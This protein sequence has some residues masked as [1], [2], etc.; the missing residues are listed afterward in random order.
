MPC[1]CLFCLVLALALGC[2]CRL[3][4]TPLMS[5][6]VQHPFP[7]SRHCP[8]LL[9][10]LSGIRNAMR[11]YRRSLTP[12]S[13]TKHGSF[14]HVHAAPTSSLASGC[15]S[16]NCAPIVLS[17]ATKH[18]GWF[19]VFVSEPALNLYTPLPRL[20]DRARSIPS[21]TSWC[22]GHGQCTRW[23]SPTPFSMSILTS[24]C[25]ASSPLV[26]S[27]PHT[28]IM[29]AFFHA[30]Y[31]GSSRH[32]VPGTSASLSFFIS[33]AS[34]PLARKPRSLPIDRVMKLP[35]YSSMNPSTDRSLVLYNT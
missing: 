29:C 4:A 21:Y 18:V 34:A 15:S 3:V 11:P 6:C 30:H 5:M 22:L 24:M 32:C 31:M 26:L 8:L 9:G 25:I 19:E 2:F 10:R 20:S 12:C 23:M 28:Q 27:M 17:R 35:T 13:A 16:R 14:F 33:S 1:M 7:R